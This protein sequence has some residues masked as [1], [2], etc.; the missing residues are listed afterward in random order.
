MKKNILIFA[1]AASLPILSWADEL[2]RYVNPF[3]GTTTLWEPEDLGYTRTWDGTRTWGGETSPGATLPNAMVQVS[4]VT[5]YKSGSGYQYEDHTIRGFAHTCKGHWNLLH[6]P[7]MPVTGDFYT[8]TNFNSW[9]THE[10][11]EAHPGYYRVW[12]QRYNVMAEMTSTLRCAFHR[13]TFCATD[14][15]RLVVDI[16]NNNN[17]NHQ[18]GEVK[19]TGSNSFEGWQDGEGRIYFYAESNYNIDDLALR[20][21]WQNEIYELR[22]VDSQKADPL[23]LR[24]GFSFVSIENAKENFKAE[25]ADKKFQQVRDD[26]DK[27]WEELLGHIKVEGGNSKTKQM[28]YSTLYRSFLYPCLRSDVNGEYRDALGQVVKGGFRYYNRPLLEGVQASG[29]VNAAH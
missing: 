23:E 22:F 29:R 21:D 18:R 1:F 13:Y 12:L 19:Q 8:P 7:V 20:K 3:I 16:H 24:M 25:I 26:A 2:T 5:Q 9:F 4:P 11:E 10:E 28:F 17:G 15:K 27:T 14:E 6:L